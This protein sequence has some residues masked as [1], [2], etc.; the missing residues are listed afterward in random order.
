MVI[1]SSVLLHTAMVA[2]APQLPD[3]EV[4]APDQRSTGERFDTAMRTVQVLR[5]AARA[6]K[7]KEWGPWNDDHVVP[8]S[9]L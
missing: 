7:L 5:D 6:E 4:Q 2:Y 9:K 1:R 3:F 8:K